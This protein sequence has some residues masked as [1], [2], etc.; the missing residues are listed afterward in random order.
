MT[1]LATQS[2]QMTMRHLRSFSRQPW[3][4]AISL[5]QPVIWLVLFGQL[6]KRVVELPGFAA[7]S[8]ITF[9]TPAIVVMTALF[10]GAWAGMGI[11]Q[12]LDRGVVDRFLIT[13][14]RRGALI[15]GRLLQGGAISVVQS[16]IIIGLGLAL[17]ARFGNG[18]AGLA[19][20]IVD[21][22]LLGA[23][24]G[25]LSIAL[26]LVMRREES[27]I[28]AVQFLALP[29]QFLSTAF[30][31]Q[32]LI[33]GWIR[34]ASRYNPVNWALE[35]ARAALV[36]NPDWGFVLSHAAYLLAFTVVCAWLSVRAFRSYQRSI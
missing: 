22:A 6:F 5:A 29:L 24:L 26:A 20:L 34:T 8:Y 35:S 27:L 12:D 28:G 23:A 30:M 16:L 15:I 32:A 1:T 31:A 19:V 11:I 13:P 21:A 14:V 9:L 4:M 25:S 17:G 10:S 3:W 7:S 33:P 2:G 18:P 36:S